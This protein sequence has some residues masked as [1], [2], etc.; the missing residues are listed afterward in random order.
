M[1]TI[2]VMRRLRRRLRKKQ[3]RMEYDQ[4]SSKGRSG[5]RPVSA[6]WIDA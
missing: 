5:D 1:L 3:R 6:L 2:P 4:V